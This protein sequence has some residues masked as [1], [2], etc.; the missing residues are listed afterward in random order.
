MDGDEASRSP[1]QAKFEQLLQRRRKESKL[2][3]L[4]ASP[5]GSV[6]F[7]SNDFLS[8]ST[9][10]TLR[11]QFLQ[12]LAEATPQL[13]STGARLL[14]GNSTYSETLEQDIATFHNGPTG[15]LANSGFDA[16][17]GI[18]SC[19]PQPGDI[20]LYDELIH[21]SVHDG[22]RLSR[23]GKTLPF[24]HN[25]VS[26]LREVLA[27]C[28]TGDELLADGRRS[29]FVAVETV[30]SMEGDLAP[31]KEIL[32][33]ME[34]LCPRR[35]AHMIVDEAHATG[36]YGHHGKGRVCELGLESRIFVRLHTFG[37]ALACNGGE[38]HHWQAVTQML[39][40]RL[41]A[42][43]ICSPLTR[44]YLINYARPLIFTTFM[45][46]PALAAIRASY[47]FMAS[48]ATQKVILT[49]GPSLF[50]ANNLR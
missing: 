14:D 11:A 50:Q 31:L 16:N 39:I 25:S 10:A 28:I 8:L 2:R 12:E 21:A 33:V 38:S 22:M 27:A 1:L 30:Y 24:A 35:N 17:V 4:K 44:L 43:I 47:T 29:V 34:E 7:S 15:L 37:K 13:G 41:I 18:F 40:W 48:G 49:N 46:Y 36:L 19:L 5:I 26:N 9:S 20:V 42:I 6:D 45:S 3:N 32:D 23:A